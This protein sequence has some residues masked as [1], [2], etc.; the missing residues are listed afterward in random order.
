MTEWTDKCQ[1]ST[2]GF[3]KL[4]EA[5][6]F[7][8]CLVCTSGFSILDVAQSLYGVLIDECQAVFESIHFF[9]EGGYFSA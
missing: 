4:T 3:D 5:L 6:Q 9:C 2:R 8:L 1:D 7:I